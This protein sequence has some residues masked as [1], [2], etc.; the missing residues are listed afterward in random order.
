MTTQLRIRES[1]LAARDK[2]ADGRQK[3]RTQHDAGSP[4]IQVCARL[5]DLVDT[6]VTDLYQ[7]AV[8]ELAHSVSNVA[9]VPHGGYGRRDVAP[10]S[11]VDLMFLYPAGN[12]N[13]I[14]PLNP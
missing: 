8:N 6:V 11:D 10:F 13:A 2:L 14:A 9:L 4:G 1:V 5:T 12:E 3:L 7:A